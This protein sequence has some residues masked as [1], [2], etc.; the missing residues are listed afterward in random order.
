MR[1]KT[2]LFASKWKNCLFCADLRVFFL[3]L[4]SVI[5]KYYVMHVNLVQ[6]AR[7][8]TYTKLIDIYCTFTLEQNFIQFF[9]CCAFCIFVRQSDDPFHNTDW[10]LSYYICGRKRKT[11]QLSLQTIHFKRQLHEMR[12]KENEKKKRRKTDFM[13][14]KNKVNDTS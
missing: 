3:L 7:A 1:F 8:H 13:K 5:A 10:Y 12:K 14:F 4:F 11:I 6:Y 2:C 9:F